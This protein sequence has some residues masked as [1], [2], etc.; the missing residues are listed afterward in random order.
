MRILVAYALKEERIELAVKGAEVIE[1]ITGMGKTQAAA[2][3]AFAIA[4]HKPDA[5]LNIGTV[6]SYRHSV[7]DIL[8]SRRFVDRDMQRLPLDGIC[9]EI[10][11]T[12]SSFAYDLPSVVGGAES[13]APMAVNTGDNFVFSP[14]EDLG[15]DAVDMESFAFAWVC[16]KAGLPFLAVKYVTDKLGQNSVEAWAEKLEHARRDLQAYFSC[17][18]PL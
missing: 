13:T 8:V 17:N 6:G 7:G 12:D 2:S 16:R 10:D 14:E 5:V 11:M 18:L 9:K 4:E 3:L 15:C 1:V